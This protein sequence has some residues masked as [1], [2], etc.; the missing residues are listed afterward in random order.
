MIALVVY[1]VMFL[2]ACYATLCPTLTVGWLV[3]WSV[4]R[5]VGR[6]VGPDFT[7]SA[8]FSVL[9]SLLLPKCPSDRDDDFPSCNFESEP[10]DSN[11][12]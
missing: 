8:F 1:L 3:G 4:G 6:L 10:L 7:Y 12:G 5:S 9:S 11:H 2:V